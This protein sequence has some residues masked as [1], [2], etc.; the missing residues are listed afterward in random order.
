M[1]FL[2]SMIVMWHRCDWTGVL[3]H[4][5]SYDFTEHLLCFGVGSFLLFF[6]IIDQ[7]FKCSKP[8]LGDFSHDLIFL[9][10]TL[11]SFSES[12]NDGKDR[13]VV[14]SKSEL[15]FPSE[16]S[17]HD[18]LFFRRIQGV[19]YFSFVITVSVC[20]SGWIKLRATFISSVILSELPRFTP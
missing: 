16:T 7:M 6:L 14:S 8:S 10:D 12:S 5:Y 13:L 17:N 11:R 4:T 20:Q 2:A 18:Q 15:V 19:P 3:T 1:A 9:N